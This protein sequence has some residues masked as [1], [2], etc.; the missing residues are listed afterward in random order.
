MMETKILGLILLVCAAIIFQYSFSD[1]MEEYFSPEAKIKERIEKDIAYSL[2][3][4]PSNSKNEV[5][6]VK[7][8]FRSLGVREFLKEHPPKIQTN[9]NG[10]IWLEVE[11]LD[12]PDPENPG[13]ITQ[14]SVFDLRTK[15][16][17]AE[18]GETYYLKDFDKSG[19]ISANISPIPIEKRESKIRE[20]PSTKKK[21]SKSTN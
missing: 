14:T 13:F 17:I 21:H 5:H 7:I 18:F 19:K 11:V 6:H 16:K 2:E 20:I 1:I 10:S 12:L 15:N 8:N 3:T 9:K 4:Q